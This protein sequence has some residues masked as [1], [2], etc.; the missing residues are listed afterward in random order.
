MKKIFFLFSLC[1]FHTYLFAQNVK[2]LGLE[3][4]YGF[5]IPH[6]QDLTRISQTN[7]YGFSIHYQNLKTDKKN[8]ENCNCFH[9]LGL[10]FSYHNFGNP[11]I[12]GSASSL[13]GTFE[14]ILWKNEKWTFSLLSSIGVSYLNKVYNEVSNPENIFFS[15]PISFL[16]YLTPKV[17]YSL[18]TDWGL[19]FSLSYNHISNGGQ[20]QP[21][22]G[23]NYPMAGIGLV[24]YF[25]NNP[26]PNYEKGAISKKPIYYLESGFSTQQG[27]DGREPNISLVFAGIKPLTNINGFGAGLELN[28]DFSQEVENSRIEALMPA[29]F[30][31]HHFLFG[32][33]DFSQ[34]MAMYLH[35]PAGY[36]DYIFYQRYV[37]NYHI[38]NQ[39]FMGIGLKAHG[40]V[41]EHMDLRMGWKF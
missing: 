38:A 25:Q 37:L 26:L 32:K 11:E 2:R 24:R 1:L 7:P 4:N 8:W 39:F 10:Q 16:I 27:Q 18:T 34:R 14:P 3:G 30:I 28:K 9:Y 33:I 41:A 6:S 21:N 15:T 29:P 23:I 35:K 40:H 20:R 22:K 17:E 12:I 31:S 5:I 13:T 19:H 36:N